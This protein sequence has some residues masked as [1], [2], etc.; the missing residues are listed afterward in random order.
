MHENR[1]VYPKRKTA[2]YQ[3]LVELPKKYKTVSIIKMRK[4]R[5]NTNFTVKKNFEKVKWNLYVLKITLHK[6]H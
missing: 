1:T 4:V 3:K 6:E 2:M 5:S